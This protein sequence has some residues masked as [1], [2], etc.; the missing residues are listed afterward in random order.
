MHTSFFAKAAGSAL[1]AASLLAGVSAHAATTLVFDASSAASFKNTFAAHSAATFSDEYLF[2]VPSMSN[3]DPYGTIT[4]SA[5]RGG[6]T[7]KSTAVS[8]FV[9]NG[10]HSH[11]A[12][13]TT[14]SGGNFYLSNLLPTGNYGFDFTGTLKDAAKGGSYGGTLTLNVSPVPEPETYALLLAGLGLLGFTAR[15]KANNKVG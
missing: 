12:L 14:Y 11:S 8:F 4:V 10:D 2:T 9:V 7:I 13:L 15:R 5:N 1:I 6:A 3:S